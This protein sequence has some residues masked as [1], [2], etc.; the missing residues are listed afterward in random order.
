MNREYTA[1]VKAC[2]DHGQTIAQQ[3]AVTGNPQSL[4]LYALPSQPGKPGRLLLI[5]DSEPAPTGGELLTP[6][7]LRTSEPYGNFFTWIYDRARRA[8]VM[9]I[10]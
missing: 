9:A 6:E 8:P 7:A 2:A 1:I 4:Y 3:L 5:P 10:D